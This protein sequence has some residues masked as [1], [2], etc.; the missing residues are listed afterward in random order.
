V[1]CARLLELDGEGRTTP[2][3]V[4]LCLRVWLQPRGTT[5]P[6]R[7]SSSFFRF[8]SPPRK[9]AREVRREGSSRRRKAMMRDGHH[10]SQLH[11]SSEE[12]GRRENTEKNNSN[13]SSLFSELKRLSELMGPP[14]LHSLFTDAGRK[15]LGD[16]L[17]EE[18]RPQKRREPNRH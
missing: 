15:A 17:R 9:S 16:G 7:E 1:R 3:C 2:L 5:T 8:S 11:A 18:R 12:A 10:M 14:A 6:A 13:P 4:L